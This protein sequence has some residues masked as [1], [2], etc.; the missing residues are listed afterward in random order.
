MKATAASCAAATVH[1][2]VPPASGIDVDAERIQ[3]THHNMIDRIIESLRIGVKSRDWRRDHDAHTR[4]PQHVLEMDIV[5]GR[6]T[7]H[8]HKLAPLL[9]NDVGGAM[10]QVIAVPAGNRRKSTHAAWSN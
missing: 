2:A 1:D 9:E 5:E 3:G 8:Q 10:N 4:E 7:H 6:F